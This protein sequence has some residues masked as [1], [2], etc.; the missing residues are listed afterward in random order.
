M[1]NI[2]YNRFKYN[3]MTKAVNLGAGG[4]TILVALMKTGHSASTATDNTWSQVS[5]NELDNG[6]GYITN[7][8]T[9]GNQSVAQAAATKFDGDD[10]AWT[11]ASFT[12]YYAVLYDTTATS[13]LICSFDFGGAKTVASGTFTIVYN[14]SGIITLT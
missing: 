10:T 9:L 3:L 14:A 5:A 11:S 4:D 1:A 2:L 8:A 13:N 6:S 12:A 7:G